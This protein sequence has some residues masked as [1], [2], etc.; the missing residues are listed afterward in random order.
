[1]YNKELKTQYIEDNKDRNL[2]LEKNMIRFFNSIEKYEEYLNKDLSCFTMEEI[3]DY[4][5]S[6]GITS[7]ESLMVMNSQF[8]LYTSYCQSKGIVNDGQNHYMELTT[9]L[10]MS[11]VNTALVNKKIITREQLVS[12]AREQEN[13]GDRFL[14]Y[15]LFE[16]IGGKRLIEISSFEKENIQKN[17]KAVKL[18]TGRIVPVT[19]EFIESVEEACE[20]YI[21]YTRNKDFDIIERK[22]KPYDS[23]PFKSLANAVKDDDRYQQIYGRIQ[24]IKKENN[25]SPAITIAGLQESGRIQMIKDYGVDYNVVADNG[26]KINI[27]IKYRNCILQNKKEIENKY[28]QIMSVTRYV[29]KYSEYLRSR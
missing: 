24:R 5:K 3:L 14:L 28:G 15:A 20:E 8:K 6:L 17:K 18:C 25:D 16:G 2:T 19:D 1:M 23:R 11:C 27:D 21:Y 7:L 13:P 9:D 26:V 12:L 4:Y 22:F 29:E 10:F